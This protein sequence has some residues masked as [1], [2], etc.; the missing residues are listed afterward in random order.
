M[1]HDGHLVEPRLRG[2]RFGFGGAAQALF[3]GDLEALQ[4]LE[5]GSQI[6]LLL[7]RSP[8]RSVI[9]FLMFLRRTSMDCRKLG[10]AKRP[11]S[12]SLAADLLA[13]DRIVEIGKLLLEIA[14]HLVR[15]SQAGAS[16]R[17]RESVSGARAIPGVSSA[18]T[19]HRPAS[20]I[21]LKA[22]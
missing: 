1:T 16:T 13:R 21:L 20:M 2:V 12:E 22:A 3:L 4:V 18:L 10:N 11:I 15:A 14:F 6:V 5:S 19:F 7:A 9:V 17:R 8:S